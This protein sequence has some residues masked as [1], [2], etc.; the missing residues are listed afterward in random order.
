M[1]NKLMPFGDNEQCPQSKGKKT[2][3]KKTKLKV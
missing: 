1:T 2:G 3:A